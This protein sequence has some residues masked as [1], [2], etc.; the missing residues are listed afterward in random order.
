VSGFA[1]RLIPGLATLTRSPTQGWLSVDGGRGHNRSAEAGQSQKENSPRQETMHARV[2]PPASL[3]LG[4]VTTGPSLQALEWASLKPQLVQATTSREREGGIPG[5]QRSAS[6]EYGLAVEWR[7]P[8]KRPLKSSGRRQA[9]R[10]RG[11]LARK[12]LPNP[13]SRSQKLCAQIAG[14]LR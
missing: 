7:Q 3:T 6:P 4:Q 8:G 12:G 1:L 9:M 10:Q 14:P 13:G 2:L 5:G 11:D